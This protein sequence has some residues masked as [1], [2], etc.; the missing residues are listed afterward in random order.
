MNKELYFLRSSE[1][2]IVS[3]MFSVAHPDKKELQEE[4]EKYTA[5]YGLTRKDL[6]LYA[7]VENSV[8]GAIWARKFQDDAH[9]TLSMAITQEFENQDIESFMMDQFLLE[10]ATQFEEIAVHLSPLHPHISFYERYDFTHNGNGF[11][12]KKLQKREIVRPSDGY[13]FS[14][15]LD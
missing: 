7:M 11:W 5:F 6:G 9:A 8:A 4:R 12:H 15:W 3:D 1:Q 2:K 14:K 10:A 13:D